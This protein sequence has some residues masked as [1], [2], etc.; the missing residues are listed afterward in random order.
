[1][2]SPK[3]P[4]VKY[5]RFVFIFGLNLEPKESFF[6]KS[7]NQLIRLFLYSAFHANTSEGKPWDIFTREYDPFRL[8]CCFVQHLNVHCYILI[9]KWRVAVKLHIVALKYLKN[10]VLITF[11]QNLNLFLNVEK[12]SA[13]RGLYIPTMEKW[14]SFVTICLTR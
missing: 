13:T 9:S 4:T 1:M 14:H 11:S 2:F 7:I 10:S 6:F 12:K 5:Q 3:L 8:N